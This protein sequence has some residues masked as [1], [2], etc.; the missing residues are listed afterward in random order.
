MAQIRSFYLFILTFHSTL[1]LNVSQANFMKPIF[2][3][4]FFAFAQ[5]AFG[6]NSDIQSIQKTLSKQTSA[7]NKGDLDAFMDG[8]WKNDS[9]AFIGKSGITYGYDKTLATYKKNF[10]DKSHM[11]QLQFD[12]LSIKAIDESHYFIIGKWHLTRTVGDV[13]GHFTLLFKKI[14]GVWNIIADHSS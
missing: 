7:W 10:P 12:I 6:Q 8:Y 2:T 11:G 3:I 13:G 14:N 1:F 4:L 9:L 5:I